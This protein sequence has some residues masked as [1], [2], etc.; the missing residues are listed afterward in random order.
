M[1]VQPSPLNALQIEVQVF[2]ELEDLPGLAANSPGGATF[3]ESTPL[4]RDLK[5]V[6]GQSTPSVWI[7]KGRDPALEQAI[8]SRIVSVIGK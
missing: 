1:N 3:Q 6:V 4:Q 8:L 7:P 5:L 2:K